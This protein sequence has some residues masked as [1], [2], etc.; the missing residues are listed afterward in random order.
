MH[1]LEAMILGL[2][3]LAAP[4]LAASSSAAVAAGEH[5]IVPFVLDTIDREPPSS[6]DTL[7][8]Q[9]HASRGLY[10]K[11]LLD[12]AAWC[13]DNELFLE[14][15][16]L[17]HQ[18]IDLEPDNLDARKGLRYARNPDGS[19]KEPAP[20]AVKNRSERALAEMPAK[21]GETMRPYCDSLLDFVERVHA[22]VPVKQEV[23]DEVSTTDPDNPRLHQW[24]GDVQV[25][26]R[27]MAAES[28]AGKKRRAEIATIVKDAQQSLPAAVAATDTTGPKGTDRKWKVALESA[29]VRV[30]ADLP[31]AECAELARSCEVAARVVH[32]LLDSPID[33]ADKYT[34]YGFTKPEDKDSFAGKLKEFTVE[35][36]ALMLS[37]PIAGLDGTND[38]L[39]SGADSAKRRDGAVRY[40]IARILNRAFGAEDRQGWLADGIGSYVTREV[41]GT[42]STWFV[43]GTSSKDQAALA[44]R[45]SAPSANW[46]DE[47]F[48]LLQ[49]PKAIRLDSVV[50]LNLRSMRVEDMLCGHALATFFLEGHASEVAELL[51]RIGAGGTS[52]EAIQAML[53]TTMEE[54]RTRAVRWLRERH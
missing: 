18:V 49:G 35:G 39:L 40:M 1:S 30:L 16:N 29:H 42:R 54:L 22:D 43:L 44:S 13:S 51:K 2:L 15:D 53:G 45:M 3:A 12:L 50:T 20:R 11:G 48:K 14:R 37:R 24:F 5:G 4:M 26:G 17:Y 19:W 33:F 34:I 41:C 9:R 6:G 21:R 27:W 36:R 28:A 32:A 25:E 52:P 7:E 10:V 46:L 38:V 8:E 31:E 47:A 23:I